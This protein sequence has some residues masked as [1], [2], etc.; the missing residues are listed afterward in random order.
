M[1]FYCYFLYWPSTGYA[2]SSTKIQ[3]TASVCLWPHELLD[4][5]TMQLYYS[6]K[7]EE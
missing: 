2:H 3:S 1:S 6:D 7:I 4:L 5:Q